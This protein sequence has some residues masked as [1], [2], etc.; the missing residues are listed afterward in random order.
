MAGG[1]L[2]P[3]PPPYYLANPVVQELTYTLDNPTPAQ[4]LSLAH[5]KHV[6]RVLSVGIYV[7]PDGADMHHFGPVQE[8]GGLLVSPCLRQP[9]AHGFSFSTS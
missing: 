1:Y 6:S 2:T 9:A 3:T 5:E 7:H 8:L 4:I